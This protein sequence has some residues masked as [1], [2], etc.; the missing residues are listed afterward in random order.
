[1]PASREGS[2]LIR[3]EHFYRRALNALR[4]SLA[5]VFFTQDCDTQIP[6]FA[7]DL[8]KSSF[9]KFVR[10]PKSF[11]ETRYILQSQV[12]LIPRQGNQDSLHVFNLGNAMANHR[13]VVSRRDSEA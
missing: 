8:A 2:A 10:W 9:G 13:H 12:N 4:T 3:S 1:M 5:G 6:N 11:F 7:I